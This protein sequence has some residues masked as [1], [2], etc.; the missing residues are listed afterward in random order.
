MR[1]KISD[2][3]TPIL[4]ISIPIVFFLLFIVIPINK[5]QKSIFLLTE[6][7]NSL[8]DFTKQEQIFKTKLLNIRKAQKDKEIFLLKYK[9]NLQS[10]SFSSATELKHI[11]ENRMKKFNL[12]LSTI[13]RVEKK[14]MSELLSSDTPIYKISIPYEIHGSFQNYYNFLL[15][16]SNFEKHVFFN[17][18]TV[19]IDYKD[20]DEVNV[21]FYVSTTIFF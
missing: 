15:S 19:T 12:I 8:I 6:A 3:L 17:D 2:K 4:K 14:D 11:I 1:I 9:E 5:L 18:H 13:Y 16:F 20:L 7:Q 21:K 10:T